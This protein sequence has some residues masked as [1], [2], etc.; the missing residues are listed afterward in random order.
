MVKE[1]VAI[2]ITPGQEQIFEQKM[3]KGSALL[4]AADGAIAVEL[5]RSIEHPS[6]FLLMI[7]WDN[8]DSHTAFT[9]TE[10]FA[11]F[12]ALAGPM[13]DAKP[14]MQHFSVV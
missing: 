12:R 6:T 8:I 1:H 5:L 9:T 4:L 11:A 7:E 10:D 13:F 14:K 2:S 3:V